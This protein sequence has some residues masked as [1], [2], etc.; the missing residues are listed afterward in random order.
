MKLSGMKKIVLLGL[1][2]II[3]AGVVVVALKG[4][5]VSLVYEQHEAIKLVIGKNI[6]IADIED[7]CK[8][9][10][11]DKKVILRKIELFDDAVN[12]D[13]ESITDEEKENLVNKVNEKYGTEFTTETLNITT[14][15]NIRLRDIVRPYIVPLFISTIIIVA[16]MVIKFRKIKAVVLLGKITGI[17][18]LTELFIASCISIVRVPLTPAIINVMILFAIFELVLYIDYT[19][20]NYK[21][22]KD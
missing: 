4:F 15:P 1:I 6:D 21:T 2:L 11:N 20:K 16:Y 5:N 10:F 8:E 22:L 19:E 9:V 3:V 18:V 12:I 13:V 17:I 14:N 7:I